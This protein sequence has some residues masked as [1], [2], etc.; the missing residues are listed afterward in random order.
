VTRWPV[1][2]AALARTHRP[3][4]LRPSP[5]HPFEAITESGSRLHLSY[6]EKE[7]NYHGK[8]TYEV[9]ID[10]KSHF[11]ATVRGYDPDA[12]DAALS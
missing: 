10:N 12:F 2:R 8:D 11:F 5:P 9:R 6:A 1:N 7:V 3:T 4:P